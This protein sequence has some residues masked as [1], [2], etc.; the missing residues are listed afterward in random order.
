MY[1]VLFV[2]DIG[3]IAVAN[4]IVWENHSSWM[5]WRN[6]THTICTSSHAKMNPY[7]ALESQEWHLWSAQPLPC[8][9]SIMKSTNFKKSK[10]HDCTRTGISHEKK[11]LLELKKKLETVKNKTSKG[12][13]RENNKNKS[14]LFVDCWIIWTIDWFFIIGVGPYGVLM[15]SLGREYEEVFSTCWNKMPFLLEDFMEE[16][17][18]MQV[19]SIL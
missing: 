18:H 10:K 2:E 11:N 7:Q 5:I 8:R 4:N 14:I 17:R 19:I 12:C 16:K 9:R 13:K 15:K 1:E 6:L 3:K